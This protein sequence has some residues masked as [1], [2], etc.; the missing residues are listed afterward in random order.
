VTRMDTAYICWFEDVNM[1]NIEEVGGKNASLGEMIGSL[2]EEGITVPDGFA[3]TAAAYWEFL[4]TNDLTEKIQSI[5]NESSEKELEKTGRAIRRLI[6]NS[7]FPEHIAETIREAYKKL[8][9]KYDT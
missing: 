8:S 4:K 2:K 7:A 5:L 3:T 6:L 9:D 1:K